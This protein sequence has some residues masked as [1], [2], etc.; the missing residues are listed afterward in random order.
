MR[1]KASNP[2]PAA[3]RISGIFESLATGAALAVSGVAA[4]AGVNKPGG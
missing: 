4:G 3:P 2:K 1:T